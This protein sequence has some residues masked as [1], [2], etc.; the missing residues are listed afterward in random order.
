MSITN[1]TDATF[2]DFYAKMVASGVLPEGLDISKSYTLEYA[3]SGVSLPVK[4]K[5]LGQ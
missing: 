5:L 2:T 3:N 1:T 4:K